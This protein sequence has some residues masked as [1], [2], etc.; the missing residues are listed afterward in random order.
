MSL[1]IENL[2]ASVDGNEILKGLNLEIPAG[3]VH[4][5]MGPNGSGKSTL[6]KIIAGH[7]DYEVT[8]GRVLLDG[9]DIAELEV[10]ERS[11][12]GIFLAFQYPA[13]VPGV[14]NANFLRAALQARL[15]EG[16]EI[17]AVA[18]YKDMYA[19]M[20]KLEMNR[21]FTSR[22][23]NEGFSGGEK[24]R[25][26]ILQMIMLDPRYCLLD[27]TDSG[28]DIDALKVVAK[29]VNSM[30]SDSR[31]FLVITHYQRL[32]DYIKPDHVHVMADGQIVKSGGAELALE[33]E[34]SGYDFLKTA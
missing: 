15:P 32:L 12:A 17:D 24:K 10:D 19:K 26:E 3:E 29:G 1:T 18:F 9:V 4:A 20:D 11:R 14:S 6:S 30:R 23:V 33:L 27:E 21:K 25:N 7:D 16:E 34:E 8:E 22:S 2:H 31:G 13:E 5:I 28:L